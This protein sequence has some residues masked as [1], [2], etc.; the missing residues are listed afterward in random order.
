LAVIYG[1]S[2]R[3]CDRQM[4]KEKSIDAVVVVTSVIWVI[5]VVRLVAGALWP[6]VSA[7]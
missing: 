3:E 2:L 5:A 4:W 6:G 7:I 1:P